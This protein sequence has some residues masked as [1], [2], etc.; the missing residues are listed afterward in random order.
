MNESQVIEE[1]KMIHLHRELTGFRLDWFRFQAYTSISKTQC[2]L[3]KNGEFAR[4]MNIIYFHSSL[5][6]DQN[7]LLEYTADLSLF[8]FYQDLFK[9]LFQEALTNPS[10]TRYSI[11]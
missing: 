4:V 3:R 7:R 6:D 1:D 5:I 8:C 2:D 11:A 10:S 9:R